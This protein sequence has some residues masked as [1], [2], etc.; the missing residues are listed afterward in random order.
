MTKPPNL[1]SRLSRRKFMEIGSASAAAMALQFRPAIA[2]KRAPI[3]PDLDPAEGS[4]EG[5]MDVPF[6]PVHPRFGFIGVGGRGTSLVETFLAANV[7]V[8]AV[9]DIVKEKA[10]NARALGEKA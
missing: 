5:M 4:R 8:I 1:P 7:R 3:T 2:A 9:C 10:E 6:A